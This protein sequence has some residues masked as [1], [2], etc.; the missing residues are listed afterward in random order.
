MNVGEMTK[1]AQTHGSAQA[2]APATTNNLAARFDISL[3]A[4]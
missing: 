3:P 1:P 2:I 4:G